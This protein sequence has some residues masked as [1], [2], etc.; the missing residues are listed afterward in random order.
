[1]RFA[2]SIRGFFATAPCSHT[3]PLRTALRGFDCR[4][5][6]VYNVPVVMALRALIIGL[7]K[8]ASI[9]SAR[10]D[11]ASLGSFAEVPINAA[12][13]VRHRL[14]GTTVFHQIPTQMPLQ[15][16]FMRGG[17]RPCLHERFSGGA[18]GRVNRMNRI[19]RYIVMAMLVLGAVAGCRPQQPNQTKRLPSMD[20]TAQKSQ[21]LGPTTSPAT[22]PQLRGVNFPGGEMLWGSHNTANPVSGTDYLFVSHQDID[23][24]SGKGANFA[25]LL[26]SWEGLQPTPNAAFPTTGNSG[27][28]VSTF[29]DRVN[30]A[31][32]KGMYV[33]IEPHGAESSAF[34]K[35]KGSYIY[36]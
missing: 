1:M 19:I 35:Y 18:R 27:T 34:A 3:T 33:M 7:G 20:R 11:Q 17:C 36:T 32:S 12:A 14:Q 6:Q 29:V 31:T 10:S 8:K 26:F 16:V 25:R 21:D 4:S 5:R 22:L 30:Y 2:N 9:T 28:Y 24:V 13:P 15:P 23:Y